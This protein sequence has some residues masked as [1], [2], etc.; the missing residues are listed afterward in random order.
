MKLKRLQISDKG[1]RKIEIKTDMKKLEIRYQKSMT[2]LPLH[3]S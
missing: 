1:K 3:P 2:K